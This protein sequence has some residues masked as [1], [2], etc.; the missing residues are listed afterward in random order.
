MFDGV[1]QKLQYEELQGHA[2]TK[3][4]LYVLDVVAPTP[5]TTS[6]KPISAAMH[7]SEPVS[8]C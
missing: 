8:A 5:T 7:F 6:T 1:K 4:G 3:E 2:H